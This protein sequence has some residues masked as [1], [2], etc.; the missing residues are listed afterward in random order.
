MKLTK[1]KKEKIEET[2]LA[3]V[4]T[5]V[6]EGEKKIWDCSGY[7]SRRSKATH[8]HARIERV[9]VNYIVKEILAILGE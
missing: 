6:Y 7:E 1:V 2:I 3:F 8:L 4:R 5:G 9:H